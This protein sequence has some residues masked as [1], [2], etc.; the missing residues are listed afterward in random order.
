M[1]GYHEL[2]RIVLGET[3]PVFSRRDSMG[4]ARTK[5]LEGQTTLATDTV[6]DSGR[7]MSGA[8]ERAGRFRGR[9]RMIRMNSPKNSESGS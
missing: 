3:G 2:W 1:L 5:L 4:S 8:F 6:E 9:F 7:E